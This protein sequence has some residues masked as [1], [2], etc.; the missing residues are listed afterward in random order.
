VRRGPTVVAV[1]L[2]LLFACGGTQRPEGVAERWLSSLDQGAAGTPDRFGGD[3]AV[4]A[5]NAVLPD[6]R[7]RD[8]GSLD[9]IEVGGAVV[10]G[11]A[12]A[13]TADV[14]FRIESTDGEVV[15]GTVQEAPCDDG[16]DGGWCVHGAEL[17]G[18]ASAFDGS[19]S[20]GASG[21]DWVWAVAAAVLLCGLA[22]AL[23]AVVT[24]RSARS[25]T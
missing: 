4:Q 3:P 14:P 25:P 17:G 1:A 18:A 23:L 12:A 24:R 16:P 2:V 7:T 19:W 22:V 11:T 15:T 9:R 8:P 13:A 5:A 20:A 6:W 21:T 10:G